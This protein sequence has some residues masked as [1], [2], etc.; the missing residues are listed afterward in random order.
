MMLYRLQLQLLSNIG[1]TFFLKQ[2]LKANRKWE[3][4]FG[5][6]WGGM[7]YRIRIRHFV[8]MESGV[9]AMVD[10]RCWHH[11]RNR[12]TSCWGLHTHRGKWQHDVD[13]R[14]DMYWALEPIWLYSFN[15]IV[16]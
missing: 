7:L 15:E 2:N 14:S 10:G 1:S 11:W 3:E 16:I 4:G 13:H 8:K 6:S 12:S 5:F 9:G